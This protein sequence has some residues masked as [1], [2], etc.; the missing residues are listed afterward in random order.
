[1]QK[2]IYYWDEVEEGAATRTLSTKTVYLH[3]DKA[4]FALQF[5]PWIS[6]TAYSLSQVNGYQK[7]SFGDGATL[8]TE[9]NVQCKNYGI[10]VPMSRG[11]AA[12]SR[13]CSCPERQTTLKGITPINKD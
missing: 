5:E 4:T 8:K 11:V 7:I 10:L 6:D 9:N 12:D 1:M 2:L 13:S 3:Q